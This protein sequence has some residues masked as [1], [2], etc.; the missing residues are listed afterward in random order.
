[1]RTDFNLSDTGL[2]AMDGTWQTLGRLCTRPPVQFA[3]Q[4]KGLNWDK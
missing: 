1:M 3:L 2:L 4:W